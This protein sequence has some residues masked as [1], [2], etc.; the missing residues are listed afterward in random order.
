MSSIEKNIRIY[1]WYLATAWLHFLAPVM[2]IFFLDL[3]Y[4]MFEMAIITSTTFYLV[5][6]IFELPMG[7]IT[8]RFGRKKSLIIAEL[9]FIPALILFIFCNSLPLFILASALQG[10]GQ[11]LV[12]GTSSA[13]LYD[14]LLEV[15]REKEFTKIQGKGLFYSHI[16]LA[17]TS[18]IGAAA[19]VANIRLPWILA[20]L[21]GIICISFILQFKEPNYKKK[22]Q[23]VFK[24]IKKS[25]Q[26]A[27]KH[28]ILIWIMLYTITVLSPIFLFHRSFIQPFLQESGIQIAF[29]GLLFAAFRISGSIGSKVAHKT[30]DTKGVATTLIQILFLAGIIFILNGIINNALVIIPLMVMYFILGMVKPK[31][32]HYLQEQTESYQRATIASIRSLISSITQG[33]LAIIIGV[34]ANIFSIHHI[35]IFLGII[36]LISGIFFITTKHKKQKKKK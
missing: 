22:K 35:I 25:L 29:F 33:F 32:D 15:K 7:A 34:I 2:T 8:D 31:L 23:A 21:S 3:G 27:F 1:P 4:S 26:Y 17:I 28:K 6:S 18:I 10:I 16:F 14:S 24:Q 13:I 36:I 9:V 5:W 19:Y 12:S 30:K 20:L 11:A